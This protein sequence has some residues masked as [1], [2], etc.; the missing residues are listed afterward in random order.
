MMLQ[1]QVILLSN[2]MKRNDPAVLNAK[3][4]F[5][6]IFIN[7]IQTLMKIIDYSSYLT[8]CPNKWQ[9]ESFSNKYI[10]LLTRELES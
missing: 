6:N 3:I 5:L 9:G 2:V 7:S 8:N 1:L 10:K 4:F